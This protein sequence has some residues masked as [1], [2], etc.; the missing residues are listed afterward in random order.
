[1]IAQTPQSARCVTLSEAM[2]AA[3]TAVYLDRRQADEQFGPGLFDTAIEH[4]TALRL[5]ADIVRGT[6]RNRHG[7]TS[8]WVNYDWADT[9]VEAP[10]FVWFDY[11]RPF[12]LNSCSRMARGLA[13]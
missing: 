12:I 11:F 4:H 10:H 5:R 6:T 9:Y 2:S 1:M 3:G 13:P 7:L 8:R